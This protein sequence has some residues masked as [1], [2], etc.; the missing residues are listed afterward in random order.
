MMRYS[1]RWLIMEGLAY[2]T[3][4]IGCL[5]VL[6]Q[7]IE[8]S[9]FH[10]SCIA[11]LYKPVTPDSPIGTCHVLFNRRLITALP[12]TLGRK[13]LLVPFLVDTGSPTTH[14]HLIAFEK[15]DSVV[16]DSEFDLTVHTTPLVANVNHI[17]D[18][19]HV[20]SHLNILGMDFLLD[21][22]PGLVGY[23]SEK[24]GSLK[25]PALPVWVRYD[26]AFFRVT[27]ATNIVDSLKKAVKAEAVAAL[28][29]RDAFTLTVKD[30]KGNVMKEDAP[31]QS[32]T[33]DTAYIVE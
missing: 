6:A 18:D 17:S 22:M 20:V 32:N 26:K 5:P 9:K 33:K 25:I 13:T 7:D 2:K 27:P 19:K 1:R 10:G 14:L 23:F 3:L 29:G 15:F 24:L 12:C 21:A 4:P 11:G 8:P 16:M 31:L 28:A 30:D